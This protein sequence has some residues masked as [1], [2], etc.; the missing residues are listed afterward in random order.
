MRK[1]FLLTLA[2][3]AAADVL[4]QQTQNDSIPGPYEPRFMSPQVA[5]MIR[6][7]QTDVSLNTGRIDLEIPLIDFNDPDFDFPITL[8]YNSGGFIPSQP[9]NFVGLHW[10]LNMGGM[11]YREVKGIPDDASTDEAPINCTKSVGFLALMDRQ[12]PLN[13]AYYKEGLWGGHPEN[14]VDPDS[15]HSTARIKGTEIE[16]SPDIYNFTF[17]RHSG[18][19]T[20][21][22]DG[23]V[24]VMPRDGGHYKV[25]VSRY[26]IRSAYLNNS[27]EIRITT[28]DGYTYCFGGSYDAMEYVALAWKNDKIADSFFM[29]Q[30]G[31]NQLYSGN[32]VQT[33]NE[34]GEKS[35]EFECYPV[36][37]VSTFSPSRTLIL[38]KRNQ[39]DAFH[40]SRIIAPNGRVL[41][42][43]YSNAVSQQYHEVPLRLFTQDPA[44]LVNSGITMN[45]VLTGSPLG[46]TTREH[47]NLGEYIDK[48]YSLKKIA[49]PIA[50]GTDDKWVDF[51]Y[52][53]RKQGVFIAHAATAWAMGALA[54]ARLD[55]VT[56]SYRLETGALETVDST[57]LNYTMVGG[58]YKRMFLT[59]TDNH[60]AGKH[61]FEYNLG[62]TSGMDVDPF[63]PDIDHWNYWRGIG[64]K[65]IVPLMDVLLDPWTNTIT[66]DLKYTTDDRDAPGT[67]CAVTLLSKV[68]YP[69]GGST[70]FEYEPHTY[71][72][73]LDRRSRQS[74]LP[75]LHDATE[76]PEDV[77]FA[78]GARIKKIAYYDDPA[79]G[80]NKVKETV[81]RYVKNDPNSRLS[82]GIVMHWPRYGYIW[83]NVDWSPLSTKLN[84]NSNG[85]G[86]TDNLNDHVRYSNV[87]EMTPSRHESKPDSSL[88][89]YITPMEKVRSKRAKFHLS[90]PRD[91]TFERQSKWIIQ[92]WGYNKEGINAGSRLKIYDPYGSL[93]R[94]YEFGPTSTTVYG[95]NHSILSH[96]EHSKYGIKHDFVFN[97]A[98]EFGVSEISL[99]NNKHYEEYDYKYIL[100]G[101]Y[102]MVLEADPM[103]YVSVEAKY[104]NSGYEHYWGEYKEIEFTDYSTHS[105]L[106]NIS[107][108]QVVTGDSISDGKV[109]KKVRTNIKGEPI[110]ITDS[111]GNLV[112]DSVTIKV[113]SFYDTLGLVLRYTVFQN[114]F[115]TNPP[116]YIKQPIRNY[117][118]LRNLWL[119]PILDYSDRRGKIVS[120]NHYNNAGHNVKSVWYNYKQYGNGQYSVYTYT[121]PYFDNGEQFNLFAHINKISHH[122]YLLSEKKTTIYGTQHTA[123]GVTTL[124]TCDYD[125]NGYLKRQGVEVCHDGEETSDSNY[126]LTDYVFDSQDTSEAIRR[127]K[128]LNIVANPVRVRQFTKR[129]EDSLCL[130]DF[131]YQYAVMAN[132]G[133]ES[134]LAV[135]NSIVQHVNDT[136]ID[137]RAEYLKHDRYGNPVH[138]VKDGSHHTVLLWGH[139][140]KHPVAKINNATYDEVKTALDGVSPETLSEPADPDMVSINALRSRLPRA[141]VSTYTY[142]PLVGMASA[143]DPSGVTTYYEYDAAGRLREMYIIGADGLKQVL[144]S[145]K[146]HYVNE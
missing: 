136:L 128:E 82:S 122:P 106:Y 27:S 38:S 5:D 54:G 104:P 73:V 75:I 51:S 72:R 121:P 8:K 4:G 103:A 66:H 55:K 92:G 135:M 52:S 42:I 91:N 115:L 102:L 101:N 140:G 20:F 25:D 60:K 99:E 125:E 24:N 37:G 56:L 126:T 119:D 22:F 18:K 61:L 138:M 84:F 111:M 45:Y 62:S 43:Y 98:Q 6:F 120:E 100:V 129:G 131:N 139:R 95:P 127:M 108:L 68:I 11:I 88:R 67:N 124:E 3:I 118:F 59:A 2:A 137:L 93:M 15:W 71:S 141:H 7:D 69:T 21:N 30:G 12:N 36:E 47:N 28:D 113:A 78:G 132:T 10:V 76:G 29:G 53:P 65:R 17:G 50:V 33:T 87:I 31:I 44:P 19:F 86:K 96:K 85:F 23:T 116:E 134:R 77:M 133:N 112:R 83:T 123:G 94:E 74:Y 80:N 26:K 64:N 35:T 32:M 49:L 114:N 90:N 41:T 39:L 16:A 105:D 9:D 146:Y 34:K 46:Q 143:T 117:E 40:L 1:I 109:V 57:R 130:S 58:Q 81:Y 48:T 145:N 70:R 89:I 79:G 110:W 142:H 14:Y 144:Q 63:T 97:P 13:D 107:R